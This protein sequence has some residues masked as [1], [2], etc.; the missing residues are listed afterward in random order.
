MFSSRRKNP[1]KD[2]TQ[3]NDEQRP[4]FPS[5]KCD[6]TLAKCGPGDSVEYHCKPNTYFQER[7]RVK[8]PVYLQH[9]TRT[10]AKAKVER[11]VFILSTPSTSNVSR[12]VNI[13][14]DPRADYRSKLSLQYSYLSLLSDFVGL[15]PDLWEWY[16]CQQS[17]L[18]MAYALYRQFANPASAVARSGFRPGNSIYMVL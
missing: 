18:V 16:V 12:V 7:C 13:P 11:Y 10:Y 9:F 15:Q 1:G 17:A 3:Q 6:S 4:V 8:Q 14:L 5:I 2:R